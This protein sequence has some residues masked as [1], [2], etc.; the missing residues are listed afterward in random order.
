MAEDLGTLELGIGADI[1]R[2]EGDLDRL[3]SK[4][5]KLQS[6]ASQG[7]DVGT[8]SGGGGGGELK[9]MN[10]ELETSGDLMEML[11]G[12][13]ELAAG[14][15]AA[16]AVGAGELTSKLI[17]AS[18]EQ[19]RLAKEITR[20]AAAAGISVQRYQELRGVF[21]EFGADEHDVS[22]AM[23][24]LAD[25]LQQA[26]QG[27]QDATQSFTSLGVSVADLK[28]MRPD[29]IFLTMADAVAKSKDPTKSL[30][31]VTALFGDDMARKLMPL[32]RQGRAGFEAYSKALHDSGVIMSD[33]AV[34]SSKALSREMDRFHRGVKGA[35]NGI[36]SFF[37]PA[38]TG[39]MKAVN[40]FLYAIGLV[41][42]KAPSDTKKAAD[43]LKGIG[44]SA[45][46][47]KRDVSDLIGK[48]DKMKGY[49]FS[50]VL[51]QGNAYTAGSKVDS[52][53]AE[54][55]KKLVEKRNQ[56]LGGVRVIAGARVSSEDQKRLVD[57]NRQL[58]ELQRERIGNSDTVR[59]KMAL[60]AQAQGD[61]LDKEREISAMEVQRASTTDSVT[62][63]NIDMQ[64][65]SLQLDEQRQ[66]K[67][68]QLQLQM[69]AVNDIE[70]LT[71]DTK[72]KLRHRLQQQ[73]DAEREL[74]ANKKKALE[75]DTKSANAKD[76]KKSAGPAGPS[77]TDN[78]DQ[79]LG[80]AQASAE[81]TAAHGAQVEKAQQQASLK[82]LQLD[83][84]ERQLGMEGKLTD[85]QQAQMQLEL[86]K[87]QIKSGALKGLDAEIARDKA[88]LN[89]KRAQ[90]D[91]DKAQADAE[92]Q[93]NRQ[94]ASDIQAG[95]S[96]V[97]QLTS[98][99]AELGQASQQAQKEISGA[100][101]AAAGGA[102]LGA[103]IAS[104]DPMSIIQGAGGLISGL[105]QMF[106]GGSSPRHVNRRREEDDF[107][108][109]L[110]KEQADKQ[111]LGT[112]YTII[113]ARG[114][115]N[116]SQGSHQYDFTALMDGLRD[117]HGI[118]LRQLRNH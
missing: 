84:L 66:R 53:L 102:E 32:L 94:L 1:S 112:Q 82:K 34:H 83:Q 12:K 98:Q 90:T 29:E 21:G 17:E 48:L 33:E 54:K 13:A 89:I 51:A 14:G 88:L 61:Q 72:E 64:I 76:R 63:R 118:D 115:D 79:I 110:V 116:T 19:A 30:A 8:N 52:S 101:Q 42:R 16:L 96:M 87:Q 58:V 41:G 107:I 28:G 103:G 11:P 108:R 22:D 74:I 95:I 23:G 67:I 7:I 43:G 117:Q 40:G 57:I 86:V 2:A 85:L 93:K 49:D 6:E 113:D 20:G 92:K 46:G 105:M 35:K 80:T 106:G 37:T 104:K 10:A 27:S 39:G 59:L 78:L 38:I 77:V 65:K 99:M 111:V 91:E 9:G 56:I 73:I 5:H 26:E 75:L 4:L 50:V 60:I 97:G 15:V 69:L 55:K 3:E 45:R 25:R 70:G 36:V 114:P 100:F 18:A 81:L 68:A 24:T 31:S 109:R 62:K 47:A 71:A 44:D